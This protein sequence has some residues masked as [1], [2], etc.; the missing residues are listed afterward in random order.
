[1]GSRRREMRSAT[2]LNPKLPVQVVDHDLAASS[3]PEL[4][5]QPGLNLDDE[6]TT[7]DPSDSLGIWREFLAPDF[8]WDAKHELAVLDLERPGN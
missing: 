5:G 1:M 7:L 4:L 3:D 2:R 6:E 8:Q